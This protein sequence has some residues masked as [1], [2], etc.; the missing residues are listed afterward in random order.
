MAYRG[1]LRGAEYR[2]G[3]FLPR[4]TYRSE[5]ESAYR[6]V[7][8]ALPVVEAVVHQADLDVA[9]L[10]LRYYP[11]IRLCG[12]LGIPSA[13]S[14][15]KYFS[16]LIDY[17]SA[18][19]TLTY[20]SSLKKGSLVSQ[21]ESASSNS[22]SCGTTRVGTTPA[23]KLSDCPDSTGDASG[24]CCSDHPPLRISLRFDGNGHYPPAEVTSAEETPR[25]RASSLG[26]FFVRSH[27]RQRRIAGRHL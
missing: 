15:R 6:S 8:V 18:S 16:Y 10:R 21:T 12:S 24:C 3:R 1:T 7:D 19:T 27:R 23:P 4:S 5:L 13:V 2:F 25:E 22:C 14:A 26:C 17:S 9:G 20:K 11:S